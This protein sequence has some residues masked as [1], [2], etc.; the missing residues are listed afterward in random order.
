MA[1][2]YVHSA[3]A[4]PDW[5]L[6]KYATKIAALGDKYPNNL[7][8]Q[9]GLFFLYDVHLLSSVEHS[10]SRTDQ[11]EKILEVD[12]NNVVAW[13]WKAMRACYNYSS[14]YRHLSDHLYS[15]IA[16]VEKKNLERIRIGDYSYRLK[17]WYGQQGIEYITKEQ[18][19]DVVER[20]LAEFERKI[21]VP[22]EIINKAQ[23]ID[24]GNAV[25]NY[26]RAHLYLLLGRHDEAVREV[27][28]AVNSTYFSTH[29]GR[30]AA[31][32]RDVLAKVHFPRVPAYFILRG[33]RPFEDFMG[34]HIWQ[35]MEYDVGP[36]WKGLSQIAAE[37]EEKGD[38]KA[39]EKIYKL[40]IE[41]AKQI[42]K[43][44]T[45][46]TV[47]DKYAEERLGQVR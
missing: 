39:A 9:E 35:K 45:Y 43:E 4:Y 31:C 34:S 40:T 32:A 29:Q 28:E 18:L 3:M 17:E 19:D 25:Y 37:Y 2:I 1:G 22:L 36:E 30:T 6:E 23:T 26:Y 38:F 27:E 8:I 24:K 13:E 44:Q 46:P 16:R 42:Q 33:Y 21:D 12:P 5:Y 7:D 10:R 11:C 41:A 14:R 47:I 15:V 20:M